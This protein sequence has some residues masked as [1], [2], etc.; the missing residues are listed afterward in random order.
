MGRFDD[1]TKLDNDTSALPDSPQSKKHTGKKVL[2]TQSIV[3]ELQDSV[4]FHKRRPVSSE[5]AGAD[6]PQKQTAPSTH[7][8]TTSEGVPL[9]VPPREPLIPK[10]KRV[11]KQRQP[12]DIYE[13][14]SQWLKEVAEAEKGF[15]NGRG[16]SQMVREALD[17]YRRD[18]GSPEK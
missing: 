15:V 5:P 11:I 16:M 8:T 18:H 10:V 12:F 14:Q 9:P 4:Y 3:N 13:D 17:N 7:S 2:N 1:L 6:N